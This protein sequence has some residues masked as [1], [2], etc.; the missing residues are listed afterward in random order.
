MWESGFWLVTKEQAA[1]TPL[2]AFAFP[3]YWETWLVI[4]SELLIVGMCFIYVE[5]YG[6]NMVFSGPLDLSAYK[7]GCQLYLMSFVSFL[8]RLFDG[9]YWATTICLGKQ[10]KI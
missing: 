1:A 10:S 3:F 6:T 8:W 5:G 9:W 7:P 2:M 4:F